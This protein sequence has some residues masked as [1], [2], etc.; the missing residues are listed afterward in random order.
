MNPGK[1]SL[2]NPKVALGFIHFN[3]HEISSAEKKLRNERSQGI[4]EV[5]PQFHLPQEIVTRPLS[6]KG[7]VEPSP[8]QHIRWEVTVLPTIVP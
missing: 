3:Y 5:L 8:T 1:R 6:V 4:E 7:V 2:E